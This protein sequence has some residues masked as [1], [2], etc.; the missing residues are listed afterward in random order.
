MSWKGFYIEGCIRVV[1]EDISDLLDAVVHPL[2]KVN[3]GLLT[4]KLLPNFLT[5]HHLAGV[6]DQQDEK[7]KGLRRQLN[8]CS[9]FAQ[10]VGRE[11]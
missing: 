3:V 1:V 6:T 7:L 9:A 2:L 11:I 8:K 10:L 5:G 4:P